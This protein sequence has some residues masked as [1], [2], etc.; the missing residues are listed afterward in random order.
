MDLRMLSA[1]QVGILKGVVGTTLVFA[2]GIAVG[3]F[4]LKRKHEDELDKLEKDT[5][6][7]CLDFAA[8]HYEGVIRR[9]KKDAEKAASTTS[10][11][12]SITPYYEEFLEF[13]RGLDD[14]GK[15]EL[16]E[17]Q[18]AEIEREMKEQD[19][20]FQELKKD[21]DEK[22]AQ[23]DIALDRSKLRLL[24]KKAAE[25][26]DK[27]FEEMEHEVAQM[28]SDDMANHEGAQE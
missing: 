3:L 23:C 26:A 13:Q 2:T 14:A 4:F 24:A 27:A 11:P 10:Q 12:L 28:E 1:G 21:L 18:W 20:A 5:A 7:T 9:G 6:M 16:S 25:L 19:Q 15:V 17:E 8:E 22:R